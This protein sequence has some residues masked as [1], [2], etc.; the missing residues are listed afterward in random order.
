MVSSVASRGSHAK[1]RE[2]SRMYSLLSDEAENAA[3]NAVMV[4]CAS[5][6]LEH[7][8]PASTAHRLR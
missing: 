3:S 8:A 4:P 1:V 2:M 6:V 7:D 5:G